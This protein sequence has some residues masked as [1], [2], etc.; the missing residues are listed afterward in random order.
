MAESS[1][2]TTQLIRLVYASMCRGERCGWSEM[3]NEV[4][5]KRK[6]DFFFTPFERFLSFFKKTDWMGTESYFKNVSWICGI[7]FEC[8]L[9]T[10]STFWQGTPGGSL[11]IHYSLTFCPF[12]GALSSESPL[13][14]S[15]KKSFLR[16][17]RQ[18][19]HRYS[20]AVFEP[21]PRESCE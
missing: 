11:D 8:C 15:I 10:T 1:R 21:P 3:E 16:C 7:F 20:H 18:T 5:P 14:T 9:M 13:S 17:T 19:T 6:M 2:D 4:V 12:H